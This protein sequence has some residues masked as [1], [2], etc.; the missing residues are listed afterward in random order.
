MSNSKVIKPLIAIIGVGSPFGADCLGWFAVDRLEC[1]DLR[2]RFPDLRLD[3]HQSDRPGVRLLEQVRAVDAAIIIDAMQ[4]GSA[5]GTLRTFTPGQLKNQT[6]E[7]FSSHG[8]GV[9]A[10]IALGASL[11]E[12]PRHLH[13]IGVEMGSD[14]QELVVTDKTVLELYLLIEAFLK[15]IQGSY[16]GHEKEK[17]PR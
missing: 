14:G 10:T 11:G 15:S 13:I 9:A 2:N 12:I 1:S 7:L 4:T 3:F 6:P 16:R 5:P 8:F 17:P